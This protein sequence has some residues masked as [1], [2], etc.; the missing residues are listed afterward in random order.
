MMENDKVL[1]REIGFSEKDNKSANLEFR[2]LVVEQH[3]EYLDHVKNVEES[4]IQKVLN[5]RY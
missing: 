3:E 1:L 5:K 2:N 4:I